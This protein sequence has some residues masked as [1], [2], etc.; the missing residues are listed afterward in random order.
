[1]AIKRATEMTDTDIYRAMTDFEEYLNNA[2]IAE[3]I[4]N[5]DASLFGA[6]REVQ[7]K[8]RIA[9]QGRD[10]HGVIDYPQD[11]RPTDYVSQLVVQHDVEKGKTTI[12][13][14]AVEGKTEE[15][16]ALE[17]SLMQR[18]KTGADI[19]LETV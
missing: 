1:M 2:G 5:T 16:E 4:A 8:L 13:I 18:V 3:L 14:H 17:M 10:Y 6:G 11:V 15:A 19:E 9:M 7:P 12:T